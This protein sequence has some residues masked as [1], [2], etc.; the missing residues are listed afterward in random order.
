MTKVIP[1]ST[2]TIM[3]SPQIYRDVSALLVKRITDFETLMN[4][5][6]VCKTWNRVVKELLPELME[7]G[8]FHAWF[9]ITKVRFLLEKKPSDL[10]VNEDSSPLEMVRSSIFFGEEFPEFRVK[11]LSNTEKE[12]VLSLEYV[13]DDKRCYVYESTELPPA[14]RLRT[15]RYQILRFETTTNEWTEFCTQQNF[16]KQDT[17]MMTDEWTQSWTP[18]DSHNQGTKTILETGCHYVGADL[19]WQMFDTGNDYI[20]EGEQVVIG[21][22]G[23]YGEFHCC[24]AVKLLPPGE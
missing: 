24:C 17:K 15:L 2:K 11:L 4:F 16:S 12:H 10:W 14:W 1:K 13:R 21:S 22:D 5:S 18:Q 9:K 7:N 3:T 23:G 6:L 19:S 20:Q 8:K